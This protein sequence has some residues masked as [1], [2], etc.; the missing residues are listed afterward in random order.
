MLGAIAISMFGYNSTYGPIKWACYV[1][2]MDD[3]GV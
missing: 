2:L 1:E 3:F